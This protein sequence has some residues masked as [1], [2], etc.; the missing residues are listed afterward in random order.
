MPLT[1]YG[2]SSV[3]YPAI[4]GGTAAPATYYFGLQTASIWSAS[5]VEASGAYVIPTAFN[6]FT[7]PGSGTNR[8]F[9]VSTAGTTGSTEP[10]WSSVAA[11]GTVVDGSVI[12]QDVASTTSPF[13]FS[14]TATFN[15]VSGN[16]YARVSYANNT[17]NF[18]APGGANPTSGTNANI[19]SFPTATGSWGTIAAITIHDAATGGNVIA[20]AYL[21]KY[22][23]V[24]SG[25]TPSIPATTGLT[26]SLT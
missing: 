23:T 6:T 15:E 1:Y 4:F 3:A 13:W 20:F 12:W 21:S 9:V 24:T 19:I 26:L 18:P 8:I 16:G 22:L 14:T 10:A 5:T 2:E 7:T 11:G 25:I 17:T